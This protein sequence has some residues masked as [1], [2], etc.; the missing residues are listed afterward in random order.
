ML[1]TDIDE[2]AST[3]CNS[4][5]SSGCT[6]LINDYTCECNDGYTGKDCDTGKSILNCTTLYKNIILWSCIVIKFNV[7]SSEILL[8]Q[9]LLLTDIDECASTACNFT[10]SSGCTDLINDYKCECNDGYAGKDCDTG[11]SI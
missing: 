9:V 11:K 1:F 4:T 2:C 6:D 5:T 10:T 3:T 8:M 7:T